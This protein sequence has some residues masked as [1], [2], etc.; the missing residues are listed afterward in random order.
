MV[1]LRK[2]WLM[3]VLFTLLAGCNPELNNKEQTKTPLPEPQNSEIPQSSKAKESADKSIE[4][5][6]KASNNDVAETFYQ[7]LMAEHGQNCYECVEDITAQLD[8]NS[9]PKKEKA[10]VTSQQLNVIIALDSSGSMAEMTN[11]EPRLTAAKIAIAEFVDSLPENAQVSLIA[12]GHQGSNSQ[13]DKAISC[14]G[15]ET[16]YPLAAKN[17]DRFQTAVDSFAPTGYTPLASTL[18]LANQNLA[19]LKSENNQNVVYLVSDGVETC[20]GDPVTVAQKLHNSETK[21]IVNVIGFDVDNVAQQQLKAISKAGGGQYYGARDRAELQQVWQQNTKELNRYKLS[22]TNNQNRIFLSLTND[23]NK[24]F[25]C[26]TQKLNKERLDISRTLNQLRLQNNPNAEY[27]DYVNEKQTQRREQVEKWRDKL[28]A[29]IENKRDINI[30]QLEQELKA[31][32]QEFK[33]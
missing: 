11:G 20:D 3:V 31:V 8:N 23:K 1:S 19:T 14:K 24:L 16:V 21:L 28:T 13:A 33:Q 12:F 32:E 29:D 7:E 17:K 10:E 30:E 2:Y 22:N 9:L 6:P 27:I 4:E 25:L 5:E 26:I 15:I 18:E